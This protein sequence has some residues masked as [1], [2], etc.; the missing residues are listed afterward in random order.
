MRRTLFLL[1]LAALGLLAPLTAGAAKRPAAK[2]TYV[3]LY[4]RGASAESARA[5]IGRAGGKVVRQNRKVGVATVRSANSDFVTDVARSRFIAGAARN[6]PLGYAPAARAQGQDRFAIERMTALRTKAAGKGRVHRGGPTPLAEPFADLQWDMQK[7][8]ATPEK[9][10]KRQRGNSSVRVGI[11]DTGVDGSHADIAPNFNRA[12]SR[13]FTTDIPLVDGP[14]EAEPDAS[15]SD[16]NDVDENGHGTHVA[17][18]VGAPINRL[19]TAG[20][21]PD[22]ELVNIRAGQDFGYFFLQPSVDALTYSADVGIDVVNMSY[23]IDPWLYN[24][25]DNPADSAEE[26]LEQQTILTATK[27]ALAYARSRG[28]TLVSAEGNGNTDLGKPVIDVTSPDFPP[29]AERER[30]VD[31][32]CESMPL[33]GPGVIGVTSFGP[34]ERKAYYSDYG[35]EQADVSAPGGDI[36]EGYGTPDYRNPANTILAPYPKN[37]AEELGELNPDGTPNTPFVLADCSQGECEYYQY[38]QGTSMASPHAAGVAALIVA[39]RGK[40]DKRNGGLTLSPDAVEKVLKRTAQDRACPDPPVVTY[41]DP[42]LT[43]DYTA[44]CEGSEEFNGFYGEGIVDAF[45]ASKK[46]H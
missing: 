26:Q 19:G 16:P 20:V 3:V 29:G 24:C 37:V 10:Y 45:A 38:L 15:C 14:C 31:N 33:E 34:S 40:R 12:L 43:P 44:I 36:R 17:G 13:N 22:V 2:Q 25:T 1:A 4:E 42:D 30:P 21:A 23:Y 32:S 6:R 18:T 41:P 11:I 8:N 46:R 7:I 35:L 28:V 9:S 5:A 27:R 39:S